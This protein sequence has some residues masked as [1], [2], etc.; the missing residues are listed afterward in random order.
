MLSDLG[1]KFRVAIDLKIGEIWEHGIFSYSWIGALHH[2][3][4]KSASPLVGTRPLLWNH[5][6]NLQCPLEKVMHV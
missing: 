6:H 4:M 5:Q 2:T 3:F 1:P